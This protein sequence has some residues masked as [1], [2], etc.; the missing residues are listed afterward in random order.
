MPMDDQT[1]SNAQRLIKLLDC[2][3]AKQPRSPLFEQLS[4]WGL[5][6]SH[7]RLLSLL[8]PDREVSMRELAEALNVKPPSLT[9]LTRRLVQTGLIERRPHPDDNRIIL[10]SLSSRGR[11]LHHDLETE[12]LARMTK[13]LAGLSHAEQQVFLDLLERAMQT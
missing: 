7:L 12:R 9:A 2:M 8:A 1:I 11:Q 4:E 10:L 5:S 6:I 13:L 3:R